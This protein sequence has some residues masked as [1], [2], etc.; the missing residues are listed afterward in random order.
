MSNIIR[1]KHQKAVLST[2][3][4]K[5]AS[6]RARKR[7][8]S[9]RDAWS[10]PLSLLAPRFAAHIL[11]LTI[12]LGDNGRKSRMFDKDQP[13]DRRHHYSRGRG[14]RRSSH[15]VYKT[16]NDRRC[17]QCRGCH[18]RGPNNLLRDTKSLRQSQTFQRSSC[19][20]WYRHKCWRW[21]NCD[22]QPL[23]KPRFLRRLE[24]SNLKD[25]GRKSSLLVAIWYC[26]SY[27]Y[28][29]STNRNCGC[30]WL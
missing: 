4:D 28:R 2:R 26:P 18:R 25:K 11:T 19:P 12:I 9:D 16:T 7:R 24:S 8:V 5:A 30:Y 29:C 14:W 3:W 21:M 27:C 20:Y 13:M 10:E 6:R 22:Q 1:R 17:R 15:W 23:T